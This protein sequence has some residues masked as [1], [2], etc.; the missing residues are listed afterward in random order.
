MTQRFER[1]VLL[2][3]GKTKRIWSIKGDDEM[4]IIENKD[5]ITAFDDPS[6]TKNFAT[7]ARFAT[8][9]TCR[10][11]ELLKEAGIP[12]AY[13]EQISPTEFVVLKCE[14][15]ALE[16]VARRYAVGSYLKR[17]PQLA[18][19]EGHLPY[20]FHQVKREFFLKTTGKKLVGRSG[21]ILIENLSVED[22]FIINP[23]D[24]N[25][26]NLFHPKKPEWEDEAELRSAVEVSSVLSEGV[27]MS[28]MESYLWDTFLVLEGAWKKMGNILIDMKIE[29]GVAPS[30]HL[31]VA[32]V[33][34]NDS[35]RLRTV[36]WEELS[37]EAFR[38][39]EE[40]SEVE[41]KYGVVAE[42]VEKWRTPKQALV[43]WRGSEKDVFPS[44]SPVIRCSGITI[45]EVTL[46]GHKSP[47]ATLEHLEKLMTKY[48]EGGVIVVKVGMSNGL[49]PILAARTIWPVIS[50][51]A[52]LKNFP[53][54]LW[55][56]ARM[57]SKVPLAVICS[58]DNAVDNALNT[59]ALSNPFVY[60]WRQRAI[61]SQDK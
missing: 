48:P 56:S 25:M 23:N 41:R 14:M 37:K 24:E 4:I 34:D 53:D 43:L 1:D 17:N 12:V 36:D 9:T 28:D 59:L 27:S 52:S 55:S 31:V 5:D 54:D 2:N 44:V 8:T 42:M 30:G 20:R 61:E 46:S 19:P 16:V 6:F 35:W 21:E 60:A 33:I 38:Q 50:I 11:F 45:E 29:F 47:R 40:L 49:G 15:I 10:V 13:K 7:K 58:D 32:D 51:P 26:W 39:N 22:P 57:P 3:E 18:V